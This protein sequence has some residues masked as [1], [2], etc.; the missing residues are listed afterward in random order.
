MTTT[1][2]S[3]GSMRLEDRAAIDDLLTRYSIACDLRD[4]ES[5]ADCFTED[6]SFEAV[7]GKVEGRQA[8]VDYYKG[9]FRQYGPTF[10]VPHRVLITWDQQDDDR[11]TGVVLAHSEI[12]MSGGLLVSGHHYIDEYKRVGSS[13]WRLASRDNQFFYGAPL[14][15]LASLDWREPRR[16]WPGVD[17]VD[18]DIPENSETWQSFAAEID[19]SA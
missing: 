9:R 19:P 12:M 10:H 14:S 1:T 4:F 16:R 2:P 7:A 8:L 15:D 13:S 18:A 3:A 5:L 17:P 6:G 11:A